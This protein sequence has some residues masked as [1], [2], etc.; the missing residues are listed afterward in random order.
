MNVPSKAKLLFSEVLRECLTQGTDVIAQ[1]LLDIQTR[2]Q[3]ADLK[4]IHDETA[5]DEIDIE[6]DNSSSSNDYHS[7]DE[8]DDVMSCDESE[9]QTE[10]TPTTSP[11]KKR[12]VIDISLHVQSMVQDNRI[13]CNFPRPQS[14]TEHTNHNK[15]VIFGEHL[16]RP[17][18]RYLPSTF[19]SAVLHHIQ[20]QRAL[21][22]HRIGLVVMATA[23]GKTILAIFDIEKELHDINTT[24]GIEYGLKYDTKPDP[25]DDNTLFTSICPCN[26]HHRIKQAMSGSAVPNQLDRITYCTYRSRSA[27][28]KNKA[29]ITEITPFRL[30]FVVHTK[31]IRNSA[32]LKFKQHFQSVYKNLPN[33]Y[34]IRVE[35]NTKFA[36]IENA[37]FIFVLFQS[38]DRLKQ[39]NNKILSTI[40]HVIID[41]VHHLLADTWLDVHKCI[42]STSVCPSLQYYLGMTATLSHRTD[43]SG[44]K[45]KALFCNIVY[46]NFP[47]TMAK[48]LGF[49]P[50]VE[51]LEALPTLAHG[52]DNK[53][54]AQYLNEFAN[55]LNLNGFIHN[56]E[57]S[58]KR[59]KIK[60]ELT[61]EYIVKTLLQ[62]QTMRLITNQ[63]IK[64]RILIFANNANDASRIAALCNVNGLK[65]G[66]VHYKVASNEC[67]QILNRFGAAKLNV[68]VNVNVVN[69]GY[70]L[71]SVD[72]VVMARLT[73]SEIIFVQQLGRGLRKDPNNPNKQICI[74]DLAL[75]LRRR[76]K[77]LQD[78][79]SDEQI[80]DYILKFWYVSN[81]VGTAITLSPVRAKKIK[82]K[83]KTCKDHTRR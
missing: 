69:E 62:Y 10:S 73:S 70:D 75:N 82:I 9:S 44:D 83:L 79:I 22:G 25:N 40:T 24:I 23:M 4:N 47:W 17:S 74:L 77:V 38:F 7:A 61:P 59:L 27:R 35:P 56:L 5:M 1:H 33:R 48:Q 46:I 68:L 65:A 12:H 42:M 8:K 34:L 13:N 57:S 43:V 63:P 78:I 20:W 64:Q 49:F 21:V 6:M 60:N 54:Y 41:E 53:T 50:E 15:K 28:G 55:R 45:L 81:F 67:E 14:N 36:D 32:Y 31:A 16:K 52:R 80:V 76:W 39:Q 66:A 2:A 37:R 29:K 11:H 72:C 3:D 51:Y 30:L 19:Q 71:P 26:V 18:I 58:V